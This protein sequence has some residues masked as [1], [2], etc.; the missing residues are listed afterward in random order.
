LIFGVRWLEEDKTNDHRRL[1]GPKLI[2]KL[3]RGGVKSKGRKDIW[4]N[5]GKA[6]IGPKQNRR[7]K[8]EKRIILFLLQIVQFSA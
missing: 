2:G 6:A 8:Y 1:Y 3:G 4:Q 7:G 5:K